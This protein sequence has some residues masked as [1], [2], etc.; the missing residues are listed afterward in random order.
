MDRRILI[1]DDEWLILE[2][3][4][5]ALADLKC[6][7]LTACGAAEALEAL[8]TEQHFD[9]LITDIQMPGMGGAELVERAREM[10]P[11]LKV[12]VA[13]GRA[14]APIGVPLL[15]KPFGLDDLVRAVKRHMTL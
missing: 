4:K 5:N 13:S 2:F 11:T 7:V 6:E 3:A 12:I 15:R 8:R 10:R 14:E 9:L 1:V